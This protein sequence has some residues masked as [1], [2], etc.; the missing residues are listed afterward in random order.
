M[1]AAT[2]P[3]I[4][5]VIPIY[6][7]EAGLAALFTRLYP[8]LD[9]LG[10]SYELVLVDDGSRDRS[11]TLLHEQFERRPDVT[12]VVYLV[13]QFRPAHGDPGGLR[14]RARR[15]PGRRWMRTC[16][17]RPRRSPSSSPRWTR[18]TTTSAATAASAATAPSGASPRGRSTACASALTDIRMA[19]H[20]CMLRAYH[21]DVVDTINQSRELNTFVPALAYL[22]A[23]RPTEIEVRHEERAA[24]ASNTRSRA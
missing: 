23:H 7:E 18:A 13:D 4:S 21:R 22:Y 10:R 19:D 24:G 11:A 2:A 15:G 5:V 1:T 6:N 12:R 17:T 16:R 20:G 14:A 3:E 8:A 9:A